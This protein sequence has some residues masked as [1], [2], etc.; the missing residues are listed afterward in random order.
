MRG[1][2]MC[3]T[4]NPDCRYDS[5]IITL[6]REGELNAKMCYGKTLRSD[7]N[8]ENCYYDCKKSKT[9][10]YVLNIPFQVQKYK[11]NLVEEMMNVVF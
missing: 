4:F 6:S 10:W 1:F 7:Q 2:M 8:S 11:M 9:G 3:N 5:S